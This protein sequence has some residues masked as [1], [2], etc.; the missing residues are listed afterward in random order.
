MHTKIWR[1]DYNVQV[2][3]LQLL[4]KNYICRSTIVK[5]IFE[6]ITLFFKLSQN[7]ENFSFYKIIFHDPYH[8]YLH[9]SYNV[10]RKF[11]QFMVQSSPTSRKENCINN[12]LKKTFSLSNLN[13]LSLFRNHPWNQEIISHFFIKNWLFA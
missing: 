7:K 4:K 10:D 8:T 1:I 2:E 13:C 12:Y 6:E 5:K 9:N 11:S 3:I